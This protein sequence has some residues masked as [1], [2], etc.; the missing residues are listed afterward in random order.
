MWK[1]YLVAILENEDPAS[2]YKWKLA[3]EK[4][5]VKF[6]II[7]LHQNDW[8]ER[9]RAREYSFCLLK[10]PG[11]I[12]PFKQLYD[13]RVYIIVKV[14][15]IKTF[16]SYEE[17]YIYENKKLLSYF[18]KARKIPHPKTFVFYEKNDALQFVN[19]TEFPI[20]AKT[21]IG[22]SG[23]G[24]KI[25]H[26]REQ[27]VRYVKKAFSRKGIRRRFG[28]NR[29]TGTPKKWFNKAIRSPSY[30][31][32]KLQQYMKRNNDTQKW[33]VLFQEY[34][35][36]DFEWRVTRIGESY[37]AHKKVKVG[38]KASGSKGIDYVKPPEKLLNFVKKTC[39]ENNFKCMSIDLF[40]DGN[41]G[42]LVNELQTIFGHVQKF[43]C[44]IDGERG[45]YLIKN[46]KWQFEKGEFN[47]NESYDLRLE[48]ALKLFSLPNE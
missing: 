46:G 27:A 9:I 12:E 1:K 42:Y 30:F 28:P 7:K 26:T 2:S 44:M 3:C 39:D 29:V 6:D 13:E 36:H 20:V 16:P 24:V 14:L 10:P 15:G 25:I 43:I 45:R 37:F 35:P 8:L 41:G 47:T 32:K 31:I 4:A 11:E 19:D 33:Y 17:A 38:D 22:A 40:E 34:I 21:S 23:T 18:L 48:A 5:G